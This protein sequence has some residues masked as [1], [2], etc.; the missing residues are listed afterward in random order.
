MRLVL[1]IL[2]IVAGLALGAYVGI[3]VCFAGGIIDIIDTAK[4]GA[5]EAAAIAWGIVKIVFA[6]FF[7]SISAY[8]LIVPGFAMVQS[9]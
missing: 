4:S 5:W 3:W 8:V 7:G 2:M 6:G 1:G 9:A